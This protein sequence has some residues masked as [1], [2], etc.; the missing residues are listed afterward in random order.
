MKRLLIVSVLMMAFMAIYAQDT[1]QTSADKIR[2]YKN[3]I[4]ALQ[5]AN[6]FQLTDVS[7]YTTKKGILFMAKDSTNSIVYYLKVGAK[8]YEI[9]DFDLIIN[10]KNGSS[11]TIKAHPDKIECIDTKT[12]TKM[13]TQE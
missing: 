9:R 3:Q 5:F 12:D 2:V 8:E 6:D 13:F 10:N 4:A 7:Q 1:V 11:Y